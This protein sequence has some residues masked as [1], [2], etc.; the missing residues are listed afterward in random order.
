MTE[1][2]FYAKTNF[3]LEKKSFPQLTFLVCGRE[4][5]T[6]SWLVSVEVS[7]RV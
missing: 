5:R 1:L 2:N 7:D 4:Q 6:H 3:A